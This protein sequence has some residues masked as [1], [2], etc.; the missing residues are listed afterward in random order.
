MLSSH[1]KFTSQDST[2]TAKQ[3]TEINYIYK[4][5]CKTSRTHIIIN[6]LFKGTPSIYN[7]QAEAITQEQL[8]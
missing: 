2:S 7:D 3:V 8:F 5:L 6:I 1:I 4:L